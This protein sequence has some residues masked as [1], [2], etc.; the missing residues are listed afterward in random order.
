MKEQPSQIYAKETMVVRIILEYKVCLV[1]DHV[2]DALLNRRPPTL[3]EQFKSSPLLFLSRLLYT[4]PPTQFTHRPDKIHIVC[5][6]D[7]HNTHNS[8]P[9]V[10]NG[11]ILIHAGDLTVSGTKHEL[12]DVLSWLE[13]QPHP[14]KF[15]IAGNHDTYLAVTPGIHEYISSTYPSLTYLQESSKQVTIRG[16]MLRVY[17]SPYTPQHGSWV[18]QYPKVHAPRY[19]YSPSDEHTTA[20]ES[21][22]IWSRIPLL[23]DILITHGPPLAHLDHSN[24][25]LGKSS[26]DG[27]YA[28]LTALWRVRPKLHVFGHIHVGRGVELVKWDAM[29]KAYEE[30]C[31][32]RAGWNGLVSLVWRKIVLWFWRKCRLMPVIREDGDTTIMVNAASVGGL[33]DDQRLGAISIEI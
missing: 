9:P 20:S 7:T 6:S 22:K 28:L 29:Q 30:V 14:H 32:R 31:A 25:N 10:P 17:G 8:Q 19:Y 12:D 1:F 21:I 4:P 18:F 13:S 16:R 27:C 26:T 33:K 3:W 24:T 15:F 11:D 23:T 5:I 2:M